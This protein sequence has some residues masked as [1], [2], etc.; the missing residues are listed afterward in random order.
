MNFELNYPHEFC[1]LVT[2]VCLDFAVVY[3]SSLFGHSFVYRVWFSDVFCAGIGW[4]GSVRDP[5]VERRPSCW[6]RGGEDQFLQPENKI[7]GHAAQTSICTNIPLTCSYSPALTIPQSHN[8][9]HLL[10]NTSRISPYL[11][12]LC[13]FKHYWN[14]YLCVIERGLGE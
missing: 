12:Y 1:V 5:A 10:I 14:I 3:V 9:L 11:L 4:T 7:A 2:P 6:H 8:A 13:I